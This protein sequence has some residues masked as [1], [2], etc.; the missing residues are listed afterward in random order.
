MIDMDYK[1][2]EELLRHTQSAGRMGSWYADFKTGK[3]TWTEGLYELFGLDQADGLPADSLWRPDFSQTT[4]L[5]GQPRVPIE[6]RISQAL[7][8]QAPYVDDFS[9]TRK[10]TGETRFVHST[11]MVILDEQGQPDHMI[12]TLQ[13]ITDQRRREEEILYIN[14][15]DT[16]TG[17]YNRRFFEEELNRLDTR[18]QLPIS[19]I[20]GNVKG[21]KIVN[22]IYGYHEGDSLLQAVA[23]LL[24]KACRTEDLIA[25]WGDGEFII[26]LPGTSIEDAG[27]V[28]RRINELLE[29]GEISY[30]SNRPIPGIALGLAT[31]NND[32]E[33]I[34]QVIREA[35][36]LQDRT[37]CEP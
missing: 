29:S 4:G 3:V 28:I 37:V 6:D 10:D 11:S 14:Y 33:D 20:V 25:R 5:D 34:R 36:I 31:K 9:I 21:L 30:T 13:D 24:K 26:G 32:S 16:L 7:S 22:D 12:G 2:L 8:G 1:T 35:V 18:R 17:L 23:G 19:I 27:H 15:H